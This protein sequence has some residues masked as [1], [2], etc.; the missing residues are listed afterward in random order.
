MDANAGQEDDA[1]KLGHLAATAALTASTLTGCGDPHHPALNPHPKQKYEITLKIEDA[2]GPFESVT[3]FASYEIANPS[4]CAPQDPF[5]GVYT[6]D[7]FDTEIVIQ[8]IGDNTYRGII[9]LDLPIDGNYYL[10]GQCHWR[11]VSV[12]FVPKRQGVTFGAGLVLH[13]VIAQK[14]E[15]T[16]PLKMDYF[17]P[18]FPG[19]DSG[20]TYMTNEVQD[21]RANYF[22]MTITAKEGAN[23]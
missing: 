6:T 18:R 14:M 2:P 12:N 5:N 3:A 11:F 13:Q 9:Y 22:S 23:E 19:I 4:E 10:K 15:S 16:Y 17:Y 7:G 1:M 21:H 8:T 20:G